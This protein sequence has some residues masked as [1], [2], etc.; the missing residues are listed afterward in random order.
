MPSSQKQLSPEFVDR[1]FTRPDGS[2]PLA[3]R[4]TQVRLE[5]ELT[6]ALDKLPNKSLWLRRV[7]TQAAIADGLFQQGDAS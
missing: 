1:I 5:P 2:S 3:K 7:I 4:L 6:A